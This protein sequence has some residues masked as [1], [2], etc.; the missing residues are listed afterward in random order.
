ME[1]MASSGYSITG[2]ALLKDDKILYH[3]RY[4]TICNTMLCIWYGNNTKIR[5]QPVYSDTTPHNQS[6][7]WQTNLAAYCIKLGFHTYSDGTLIEVT[8]ENLLGSHRS[9]ESVQL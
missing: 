7:P 2:C 9:L 8:P 6:K 1:T 3:I 5:I 4:A